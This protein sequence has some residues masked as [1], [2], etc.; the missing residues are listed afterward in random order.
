MADGYWRGPSYAAGM[1]QLYRARL[2]P[3]L[4]R[5]FD[6]RHHASDGHTVEGILEHTALLKVHLVSVRGFDIAIL[7]NR[8]QP[9]DR[10]S[11][12]PRRRLHRS[13]LSAR[14]ILQLAPCNVECLMDGHRRVLPFRVELGLLRGLFRIDV[15]RCRVKA[16]VVRHDD[17]LARDCEVD[18][19]VVVVARL[20][21]P[22]GELQQY[23]AT[24]DGAIVR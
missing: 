17:F 21:V 22:F 24:D 5:L 6:E 9:G 1:K 16:G 8:K 15:L 11:W 4:A 2:R 12:L 20:M 14:V 18:A 13:A 23:A 10:T 7:L 3:F 19:H